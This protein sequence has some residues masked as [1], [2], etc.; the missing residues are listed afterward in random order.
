MKE[1]I[2]A[3]FI[4]GN[5]EQIKEAVRK[6]MP[7][8]KKFIIFLVI[9]VLFLF[10]TNPSLIPFTSDAFKER[11]GNV[12]GS[13]YGDVGSTFKDFSF[14]WATLFK[15]IGMVLF[16]TLLSSLVSW[17]LSLIKPKTSRGRTAISFAGSILSYFYVIAGILWGL[18]ILG[19]NISTIFAGVSILV[20]ALSFGAESLIQDVITGLF[21]TFDSQFNVGDII[22]IGGFRGTVEQIGVRATY[23]KDPGGNVQIINNSDIRKV[24]NRS[25]ATSKA[26]CDVSVSYAA[27]LEEVEKVLAS[28]LPQIKLD[29]EDIFL[30][31]PTYV[32]VQELGASGVVLRI[33]ADVNEKD[34]F[35]APRIM[36]R[37]IKIGFD[38]AGVE[39]PFTQ[40]VIHQAKDDE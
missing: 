38:K 5:A 36:R 28:I 16:M 11:V 40:V 24:L 39:I 13:L 31:A 33:V 1:P 10:A 15:L 34:I 17:I 2:N 25:S 19:V 30:S 22:E 23:I 18:S 9:L 7:P 6:K 4:K 29:H 26:V 8:L 32:G 12:W 21:L 27:D 20:L 37:D 14:N 35:S 3:E